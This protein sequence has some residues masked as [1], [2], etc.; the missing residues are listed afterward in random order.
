MPS[1]SSL[2]SA[3]L[4]CGVHPF[5]LHALAPIPLKVRLSPILTFSPLIIWYSGLM[6]LF[7]L[8]AKATLAYL[9]TALSVALRPRFSFQ[10]AQFVKVFWLKSAP[11]CTLFAGLGST[12]K[13]V[14]SLLF[15]SYLTLVLSS[16]PSFFLSQTLWQIWQELSFLS[17]C[18]IMLQWV[19]R[20]SFSWGMMRLMSW[21][22]G[23]RYLRPPLSLVISPL[24]SLVSTLVFSWTGG[25]LSHQ[26]FLTHRFS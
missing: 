15:S 21:P 18:S 16:P 23:E 7:L 1:L 25:V 17:S 26:N 20:H 5:P 3:F 6:A 12:N 9:P 10:Q 14:I 13:S 2:Q 22:D 24:L 11:S 4:H 8:L 19:P